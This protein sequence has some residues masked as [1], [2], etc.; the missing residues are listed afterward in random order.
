LDKNAFAGAR[1]KYRGAGMKVG[2][3][4]HKLRDMAW[5]EVLP[6][7]VFGFGFDAGRCHIDF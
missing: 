1:L 3:V 2:Q 6:V 4:N 5:R 7:F